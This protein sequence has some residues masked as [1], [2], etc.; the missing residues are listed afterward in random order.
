MDG[1][2]TDDSVEIIKKYARHLA[3]WVSEKDGGQSAAIN[4]GFC[5]STGDI[6]GWLN[7]DDMYLPGA[8]QFVSSQIDVT[9]SEIVFGNC[10]HIREG[11]AKT[12][13]S[14]VAATQKMLPLHIG[15]YVI[16]PSAFWTR[17]VWENVG[18]LREDFHFAFD[19][20]WF[21]RANRMDIP[22]IPVAKYLSI[23]RMHE[24]HKTG[25]GGKKRQVELASIYEQYAGTEYKDLYLKCCE[26]SEAVTKTVSQLER[27]KLGKLRQPFLWLRFPRIFQNRSSHEAWTIFNMR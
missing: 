8:C 23:Y 11:S 3:Y 20:E 12:S 19:W 13:G 10:M 16:Q 26:A 24:A 17:H 18:M 21:L 4:A 25:I 2:S 9:K 5:R 15:D 7:S 22:F 6:L 1:G 14:D 27:F